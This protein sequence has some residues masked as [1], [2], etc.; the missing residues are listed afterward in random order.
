MTAGIEPSEPTSRAETARLAGA[1]DPVRVAT[2]DR[3]SDSWR[4]V[5]IW[6]ALS[7]AVVVGSAIAGLLVPLAVFFAV[8]AGAGY[9]LSGSV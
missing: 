6:T 4:A 7:L 3:T 5:Q 1:A 2:A 8:G 9:S